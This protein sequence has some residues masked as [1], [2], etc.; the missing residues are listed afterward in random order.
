ME[1]T[2]IEGTNMVAQ[3]QD[4]GTNQSSKNGWVYLK[5]KSLAK[6]KVMEDRILSKPFK[7]GE[8]ESSELKRK[9]E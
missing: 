9:Q 2:N 5:I 7:A 1:I 3:P 6:K 4:G 8:K